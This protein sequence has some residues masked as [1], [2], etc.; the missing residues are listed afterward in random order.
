MTVHYS[1]PVS[2]HQKP[3]SVLSPV[4]NVHTYSVHSTLS[5]DLAVP[6]RA[7]V[8]TRLTG[9]GTRLAGVG[10]ILLFSFFPTVM[11]RLGGM[12]V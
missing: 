10:T 3:V 6:S 7:G 4:F 9:V 12:A 1:S 8:G 5:T 2:V 11:S